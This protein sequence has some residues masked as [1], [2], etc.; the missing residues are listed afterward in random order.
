M[1]YTGY[2][3]S[4]NIIA[5]QMRVPPEISTVRSSTQKNAAAAPAESD[6]NSDSIEETCSMAIKL[7]ILQQQNDISFDPGNLNR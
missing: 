7:D 2:G 6:I 1:Q 4:H 5:S 3:V